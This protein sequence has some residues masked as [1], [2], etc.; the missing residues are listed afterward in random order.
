MSC[1]GLQL[2]LYKLYR[3]FAKC[4]YAKSCIYFNKE[5]PYCIE[6]CIHCGIWKDRTFGKVIVQSQVNSKGD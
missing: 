5:N 2:A 3:K 4:D 6:C 1:S